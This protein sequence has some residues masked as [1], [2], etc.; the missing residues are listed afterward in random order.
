MNMKTKSAAAV[1][2][3]VLAGCAVPVKLQLRGVKP[4]NENERKENTP[5]DVRIYQLKDN[6]RFERAAFNDLWVKAKETLA[7]DLISEKTVT[8]FPG[9]PE[10]RPQEADLGILDASA[11]FVGIMALCGK[12]EEGKPRKIAV[13]AAEADDAVWEFTGYHLRKGQ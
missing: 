12:E 7:E 10:D 4:L 9:A 11:R 3:L 13:P 6:A 1:A 8:V 5:V 2:L